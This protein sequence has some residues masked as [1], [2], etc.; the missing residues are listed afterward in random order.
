MAVD[1]AHVYWANLVDGTIGRANL[2]GTGGEPEL[3]QPR[4]RPLWGSGRRRPHLLGQAG[5]GDTI[6]RANL[7]GT[8]VD[9]G[10][11]S[12]ASNPCGVAVDGGHVYWANGGNGTIGR[13]NLNGTGV[14]Q[15]FIGGA[16]A[17]AEW[18][19]TP[20]TSA[21]RDRKARRPIRVSLVPAFNP[22][23][24]PNR[25]HGAPLAFRLLHTPG[26]GLVRS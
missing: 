11:I 1:A 23:I 3:H 17:P 9:L 15:S 19:S 5:T 10:F 18:Q 2:D 8:G 4:H 16:T 25:T 13:A 12:G 22:C 26:P 7:D 20:W 14:S 21:I 24:A 6:G